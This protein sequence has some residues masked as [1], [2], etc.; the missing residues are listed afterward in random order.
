ME[1]SNCEE[2]LSNI[3]ALPEGKVVIKQHIFKT[4]LELRYEMQLDLA[5]RCYHGSFVLLS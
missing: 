1:L 5:V 2:L 3:P 4:I